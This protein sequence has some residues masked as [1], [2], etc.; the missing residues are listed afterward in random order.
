MSS[1]KE[2]VCAC[3]Q[4]TII[5]VL[6]IADAG[7]TTHEKKMVIGKKTQ[8]QVLLLILTHYLT[9]DRPLTS[10][11]TASWFE[12]KGMRSIQFLKMLSS[13][14]TTWRFEGRIWKSKV[15]MVTRVV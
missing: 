1:A 11:L 7:S 8:N 13:F 4:D 12:N 2:G 3:Q 5:G 6:L 15:T 14:L 10:A 9:W